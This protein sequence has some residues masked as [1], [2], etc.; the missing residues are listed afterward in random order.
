MLTRNN[1]I[2]VLG[3]LG[4][5]LTF[6]AGHFGMFPMIPTTWQPSIELLGAFIGGGS[7]ALRQS[8]LPHSD[9][10][11][12]AVE[13]KRLVVDAPNVPMLPPSLSRS[14]NR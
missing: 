2:W 4:G 9:S 8:P 10:H 3:M 1:A 11:D 13:L 6:V 7:A 14:A 5:L 12:Q